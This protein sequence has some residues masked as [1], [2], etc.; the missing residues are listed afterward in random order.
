MAPHR[1]VLPL[2]EEQQCTRTVL[3][4]GSCSSRKHT[5]RYDGHRKCLVKYP[6]VLVLMTPEI[7]IITT[8]INLKVRRIL[9]RE[10][11]CNSSWSL[12]RAAGD[13][14]VR[15]PFSSIQL[16]IKRF[17][18]LPGCKQCREGIGSG[19]WLH[20]WHVSSSFHRWIIS[21]KFFLKLFQTHLIGWI[22]W[23]GCWRLPQ[24]NPLSDNSLEEEKESSEQV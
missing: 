1:K 14:P 22:L 3:F 17:F 13:D 2:P 10:T 24:A 19:S 12:I 6:M 20:S 9:G 21:S 4:S 16:N 8:T 23:L 7:I 11:W 15:K 18:Q 5:V